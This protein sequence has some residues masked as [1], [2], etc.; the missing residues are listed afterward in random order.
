MPTATIYHSDLWCPNTETSELPN[1]TKGGT[2]GPVENVDTVR[3]LSILEHEE[4]AGST[5]QAQVFL[6]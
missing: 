6:A 2:L 4:D 1:K 3:V 5:V